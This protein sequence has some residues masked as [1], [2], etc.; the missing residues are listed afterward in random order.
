MVSAGCYWIVNCM[1]YCSLFKDGIGRSGGRTLMAGGQDRNCLA[2]HGYGCAM[3]PVQISGDSRDDMPQR[4][5]RSNWWHASGP[6][7]VLP[8]L[9][10]LCSLMPMPSCAPSGDVPTSYPSGLCTPL[11]RCHREF[12]I[13]HRLVVVRVFGPSTWPVSAWGYGVVG[14]K[15]EAWEEPRFSESSPTSGVCRGAMGLPRS[16]SGGCD[17]GVSFWVQDLWNTHCFG[18]PLQHAPSPSPCPVD[19]EGSIT[20]MGDPSVQ[21]WQN[22]CQLSFG[23]ILDH[24]GLY[25]V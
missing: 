14:G 2:L 5:L 13:W 23:G 3:P 18:G 25:G 24:G 11:S 6:L 9:T 22:A 10:G 19:R 20:V 7:H 21:E 12:C 1:Q 4:L 16:G 17:V 15:S 8:P